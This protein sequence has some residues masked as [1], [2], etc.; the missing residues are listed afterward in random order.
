[1]RR[2][3][4]FLLLTL[5][6]S[7]TMA[8]DPVAIGKWNP[9]D[10]DAEGTWQINKEGG[11]WVVSLS[12]DFVTKNGPDLYVLLSTKALSEVNNSNANQTS[13]QVGLLKTKDTSAFFKKMKGAQ[14]FELPASV[15]I[16]HY[17]SILIHCVQYSHLW[18]GADL[19]TL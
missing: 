10:F 6:I 8:G 3:C 2:L 5:T 18:A 9:V 14:R 19:P 11:N 12:D 16:S 7:I 1:M 13:V 4:L 15:D 17:K